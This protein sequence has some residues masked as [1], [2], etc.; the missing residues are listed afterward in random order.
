MDVFRT[1]GMEIKYPRGTNLFV[2]GQPCRCIFVIRTGL[3]KLSLTSRE[4]RTMILRI[5]GPGDALGLSA[6]ISGTEHDLS[7]EVIENCCAKVI[8]VKDLLQFVRQHPET[9]LD[10][11]RF[12]MQEYRA[13]LHGVSR[14]AFPASAAGRLA[15]LL[16][17]L[18]KEHIVKGDA[19]GG[20][21]IPLTHRE[22]G[23]MTRTSRETTTRNLQK[24][25][26]N[27]VVRVKKCNLVVI[28]PKAVGELAA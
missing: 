2:E 1:I 17:E 18:R 27:R 6:A 3:V 26:K 21:T 11:A 25:K 23:E 22:I 24:F 9:N 12:V 7:A 19:D 20:F 10:F 15:T 14:L 4:G 8:L 13:A 28:R 5:A 16:Q